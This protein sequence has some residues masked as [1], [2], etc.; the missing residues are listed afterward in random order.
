MGL[1]LQLQALTLPSGTEFPGTMQELENLI[2]EYLAIT[3]DENFSGINY[4]PTTPATA[5]QNKPWFRTDGSNHGLGWYA[6]DGAIWDRVQVIPQSGKF[7]DTPVAVA[8]GQSYYATDGAGSCVWNGTAWVTADGRQGEVRQV[9]GTSIS[10]ILAKY[11]G[12]AQVT[13]AVGCT[14]GV[15]GTGSTLG[16]SDRSPETYTGEETHTQS[17]DEMPSH[18]HALSDLYSERM[19]RNDLGIDIFKDGSGGEAPVDRNTDVAGGGTAFNIMQPTWF[20]Y[21]IQKL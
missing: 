14:F 5:D 17:V 8:V 19:S 15:A 18:A 11:P 21:T 13:D 2:A 9:R 10:D 12:W 3:G 20:L 7:E 1:N 6:W 4:G 16:F